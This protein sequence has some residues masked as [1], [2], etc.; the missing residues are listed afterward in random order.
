MSE[1]LSR[2]ELLAVVGAGVVGAMSAGATPVPGRRGTVGVARL[3]G[4]A[5][6]AGP[7]IEVARQAIGSA[8]AAA[9]GE[10]S[11]TGAARRLFA[12]N[13]TVG[14][15]LNCLG[16][17]RMS[18]R[19]VLVEALAALLGEAGIPPERIV[20][21]DR[22]SRELGRAGFA[23]RRSGGPFLCFGIDNDFD[24]EPSSHGAIGSCFARLVSTTCTAL[25]S[26]GVVKDH[27]LAG[28]SAGLKN[29]YGVIHNPNK[30]H[31]SNCDPYVAD[32]V[33][34]PFVRGKLRLTV[35]DGGVAQCHGG[36]AYRPDATWP[37]GMVAVATDPVAID[38]WAWK[39]I[40]EERARR[41]LPRLAEARRAPR[42][43]ATAARYGLG[44]GDPAAVKE[45]PA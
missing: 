29:W 26:F 1:P 37:L 5:D 3:G 11:G 9:T 13:D 38:A 15:K 45:V 16:G 28:V 6:G 42:F 2:R 44:V 31:D 4:A 20:V 34:H 8:L 17:P 36:P 7:S 27:D 25:V 30:Y 24:R 39:V 12:A 21:F 22:S 10:A 14:I 32:V 35:L 18:P 41:G 40:D 19:P 33:S 43:I 23:I